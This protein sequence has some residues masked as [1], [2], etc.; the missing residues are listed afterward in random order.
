[1][2]AGF[3]SYFQRTAPLRVRSSAYRVLGN[4]ATTYTGGQTASHGGTNYRAKWWTLGET[5]G[6]SQW[7]AWESTGTCGTEPTDP[8]STTEPTDPPTTTEPTDPPTTAEPTDPPTTTEPTDPPTTTPPSAA[9]RTATT[10]SATARI[11]AASSAL[12]ARTLGVRTRGMP[13]TT[14][15]VFSSPN[16]SPTVVW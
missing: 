16:G 13:S 4:G 10:T 11:R 1:M 6:A 9:T 5:P 14:T 7:G 3:G 2:R 12:S 15:A 8:P